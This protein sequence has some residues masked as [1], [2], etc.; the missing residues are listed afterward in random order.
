MKKY[1]M[2]A[3]IL[4]VGT[5]AMAEENLASQKLKETV[6]TT[7]ESFGT[8][9][10]ETAKNVYVVTAEEIKEKGATT[11]T[12][13]VKGVPGVIVQKLD[14]ANAVI[15][16]RGQGATGAERGQNTMILL[17][18]IPL[19]GLVKVNINS[20]PVSEIEKIEIIQGGGAVMYGDGAV[21]G[22][23]NII[24]KAPENK[25]N[26]GSVG[27]E[28]GS[29]E[30]TRANLTYGTKIGEKL[31]V[32]A[33]YS[34][35]SSMEWRDR[36]PEY[37]NDEDVNE[38]IWLRGKY[39][40]K[41]GNIELRYNHNKLKDYFT[42]GLLEEQYKEN[43]QQRGTWGG[44]NH[45]VTDI[46]NLSYNKKLTD[47]LDFLI[48]G[49]YS[50][51]ENKN[52][53]TLTKEYFIKP[54][55]KYS[56]GDNSYIVVGGDYRDGNREFKDLKDINNN[57]AP[58]D[59]RES[60][61]GYIMNKT[62]FGNLEFTQGYRR[63]RVEYKYSSKKYEFVG[64]KYEITEIKPMDA[65]YSNNDSYEF[66]VNYLYSDTGNIYF[67]Y[68]RAMRTPTISDAGYWHGDVKTQKND[69]YEIG[70]R[71]YYKNTAIATSV[72]YIESENEI[73]YDKFHKYGNTNFDGEVRR[74]G[75]QLAL[76]HYFD[77]LTLRENIS[78]IKPE[79]TSGIYDGKTFA[80]VPEWTLNLGATY[81]FNEK[82]Y[83]N[84]DIYYQADA[85]A[86][87]D[88]DNYFGKE[89]DYVTVDANISYT[90]DN[91][92]ELYG[93]IRNLFDEEYCNT[94]TS[95]RSPWGAGPRTLFYPADGR[96]YYAGFRYNF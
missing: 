29:W 22:V 6:I 75:A 34:G 16:L 56:Y 8:S 60:Y 7:T 51:E 24:T 66:G 87:D 20:I 54:Q 82:L 70:V 79:V 36:N 32:N 59:E 68:T 44:V 40:L 73:Y 52:Q 5:T 92:L 25:A 84:T 47:K 81:R 27:L 18:G 76:A 69:I 94:I 15:D 35:Y 63:E 17:D 55:V 96:S 80:G 77:K 33:S 61:A 37:K 95:T 41:D 74:I 65:D 28:A 43:P 4:A 72:F 62:T 64:G 71:D 57:S 11:V 49:G 93:G 91:G 12:D 23:V 14:G 90:L 46:W 30:T 9:A 2:L 83:V 13:A 38:S 85:Y 39:L 19:N 67:N 45:T 1:L 53:N 86:E 78:Y 31:L 89:N 42:G 21:G 88:F 48:Y 50:E 26:Y 10:H 3:A 58:D